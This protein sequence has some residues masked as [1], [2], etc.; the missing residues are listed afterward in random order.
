MF[1][2][3]LSSALWSCGPDPYPLLCV[4]VQNVKH[5]HVPL[6]NKLPEWNEG[7]PPQE[8]CLIIMPCDSCV[9]ATMA[10]LSVRRATISCRPGPCMRGRMRHIMMYNHSSA[11]VCACHVYVYGHL[12]S[13]RAAEPG[14]AL[15]QGPRAGALGQ[16]L[17]PHR[18]WRG[19]QGGYVA[20]I[21]YK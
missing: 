5:D 9:R 15:Q 10:F 13:Y 21:V 8:S 1:S 2:S 3:H 18:R 14:A 4:V 16:E 17:P 12:W 20:I 6:I 7:A 11:C 19:Q